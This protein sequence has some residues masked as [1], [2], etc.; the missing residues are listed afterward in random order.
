MT[1]ALSRVTMT[2]Q[3]TT[4]QSISAGELD[5]VIGGGIG[6]QIGSLFGADGAKWGGIADSIF[7]MFGGMGGGGGAGGLGSIG[8]IFGSF[9]GGKGAAPST[10]SAPQAPAQP[11]PQPQAAP[12]P[13]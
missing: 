2:T 5:H 8:N 3:P 11:Q 9:L 10:G 12:Q 13:S 7:G 1:A 4:L 6:S